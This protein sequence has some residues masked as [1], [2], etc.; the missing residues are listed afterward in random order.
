MHR[1]LQS[2]LFGNADRTRFVPT[3]PGA[4]KLDPKPVF[5]PHK[6]PSRQGC[7]W[8]DAKS[9]NHSSRVISRYEIAWL[10]LNLAAKLINEL[11]KSTRSFEGSSQPELLRK[12]QVFVREGLQRRV[13]TLAIT[14]F[15]S[16][17]PSMRA[18]CLTH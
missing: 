5:N 13:T 2:S 3:V 14:G 7:F 10:Y 17:N 4:Y 18:H 16:E 9:P 15:I 12:C 6:R 8:I 11:K 1:W